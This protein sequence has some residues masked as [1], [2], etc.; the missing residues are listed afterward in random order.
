MSLPRLLALLLLTLACAAPA[1]AQDASHV[2]TTWRLLDYIAVDYAG[3]ISAGEVI[4]DAEYA[5][6]R[7]FSIS[8]HDKLEALPS[9]AAK[10]RLIAS[11]Q[12]LRAAIDSKAAPATVAQLA[13]GL[14]ADLL[15]AYP[16]ALGPARAA[17]GKGPGDGGAPA[18]A[19]S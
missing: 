10:P 4:S 7:E 15:R 1:A 18:G 17:Q 13:R 8:V 3:A 2:P 19:E 12:K 9:N 11:G 14:A 5:E 6:M 16:V